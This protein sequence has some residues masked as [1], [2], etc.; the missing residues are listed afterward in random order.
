MNTVDYGTD[1]YGVEA[2]QIDRRRQLAEI[3]GGQGMSNTPVFSNGAGIA[4]ALMIAL[5][6]VD[7]GRANKEQRDLAQRK[8]EAG[9]AEMARIFEAA[10]GGDRMAL[11]KLL[12]QS[13]VQRLRSTGLG[14]VL[15]GPQ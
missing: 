1:P 6:Q 11:A 3:L 2:S 14:M 12:A 15:K 10:Q 7:A 13:S 5:G 8:S 4:K 9:Q